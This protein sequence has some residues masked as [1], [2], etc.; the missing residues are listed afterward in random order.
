VEGIERTE[1]EQTRMVALRA[2]VP[3]TMAIAIKRGTSTYEECGVILSDALRAGHDTVM[4]LSSRFHM[5]RI[6]YVFRQRFQEKGI[7]VVLHGAPNSDYDEDRWWESE[8]G[9]LMV[10]NE[11]VKLV[12]YRLKY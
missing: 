4:I 3:D 8:E 11:Y 7:T 12:Y 5:R 2:G 10:N 6:A 1:A 9:L